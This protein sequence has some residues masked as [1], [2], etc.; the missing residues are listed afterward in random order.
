ME[1]TWTGALLE[2]KAERWKSRSRTAPRPR[3]II[4]GNAYWKLF[5]VGSPLEKKEF[6]DAELAKMIHKN[7]QAQWESSGDIL[8]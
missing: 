2:Y 3:T 5:D 6:L 7:C 1:Q 4:W 8:A